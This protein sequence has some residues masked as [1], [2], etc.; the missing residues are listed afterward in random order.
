M[1]PD[2]WIFAVTK[3]RNVGNNLVSHIEEV[4]Y[5]YMYIYFIFLYIL[6]IIFKYIHVLN[7]PLSFKKIEQSQPSQLM[8]LKLFLPQS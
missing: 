2:T 8:Q 5:I 1:I 6:Y 3:E 7:N 4:I